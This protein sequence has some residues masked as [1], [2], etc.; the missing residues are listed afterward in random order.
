M[1]MCHIYDKVYDETE[2]ASCPYCSGLLSDDEE[3]QACPSCGG[4][5]HWDGSCWECSNCDYTEN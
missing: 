4:V 1:Q 2:Y 5:M 3:T